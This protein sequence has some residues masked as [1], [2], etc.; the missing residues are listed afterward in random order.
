MTGFWHGRD[1]NF[2][3]YVVMVTVVYK[4]NWES[5]KLIALMP[6]C[7]LTLVA[8]G[9]IIPGIYLIPV[10]VLVVSIVTYV[11]FKARIKRS[12]A[13]FTGI[14]DADRA[15]RLRQLVIVNGLGCALMVVLAH[16]NPAFAGLPVVATG[17][18]A[19]EIIQASGLGRRISAVISKLS[20]CLGRVF[21]LS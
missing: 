8:S 20:G 14:D 2:K 7:I 10:D 19:W 18:T 4:M 17:S 11:Q 3:Y 12:P 21:A 9:F 13:L 15:A 16:F 1:R 6:V 5:N